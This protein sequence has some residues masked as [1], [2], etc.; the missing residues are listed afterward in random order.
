LAEALTGTLQQIDAPESIYNC[1]NCTHW[2]APGT[3]VCPECQT[4]V[5]SNHLR[6]IALAAT[7]EE[8]ASQWAAARETWKQAL[9]WLP[10]DTKQYTAVEQRIALVDAKL[11]TVQDSKAKWTKR[12]G[13][14]APVLVLLSK[15]K[16]LLILLTK[17]KFLLSFAG[18]FALYWALFGWKFA[19]GFTIGILIHEM[20]H[21]VAAR[22]RGLKVDLPMFIPGMG[23]YV[24]WYSDSTGVSL[25]DR[26][27]ISLA[28]PAAGLIF[29]AICGG[30]ARSQ[31]ETILTPGLWSAL[32]HVGAWLNLINLAP[33]SILDGGKVA[34]ALDRM[35]RWLVLATTVIFFVWLR[36]LPFLL[37]GLGMGWRLY[38]DDGAEQPHSK[39]L[40]QYVLL[41][42][43]LGILMYLFP[44]PMRRRY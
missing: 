36:E 12:L 43:V 10:P 14:L 29:A 22:R 3:L 26:A 8:N 15:L 35:Q 21:F 9:L 20:G 23:A 33:V 6:T 7:T 38:K 41:M 27:A 34:I 39:T 1:P 24:R 2:L 5:Y 32:A 31:G 42:F 44:D 16:W 40:V 11:R 25:Q 28:G 13:P 19:A 4:I 17:A 18:F 30:I 37:V